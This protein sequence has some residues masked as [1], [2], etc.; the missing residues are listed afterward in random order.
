MESLGGSELYP[1]ILT[2]FTQYLNNQVSYDE[3]LRLT[4]NDVKRL[5]QIIAANRQQQQ[6]AQ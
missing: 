4:E 2:R 1:I 5:N 6:K 3:Y